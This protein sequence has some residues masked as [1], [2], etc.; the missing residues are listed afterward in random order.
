MSWSNKIENFWYL[1]SP[2]AWFVY[3]LWPFNLIFLAIVQAKR[4]LYYLG[5][6]KKQSFNKPVIVVGNISVGGTGK[7]PF[8]HQYVKLLEENDIRVGLVS[9]G[10][11]AKIKDFPHQVKESDQAVDVGDEA[12]LQFSSL[13]IP[14]VIDPNRSRAVKYLVDSNNVDLVISDDGLQHYKMDRQAEIVLFDGSRGLGNQLILPLGPLREPKQRLKSVNLV[15]ENKS[16]ID[17]GT[18]SESTSEHDAT[19]RLS[20]VCF[21]QLTTNEIFALESFKGQKIHGVAAIGN[22]EHFFNSLDK[23]CKIESRR[24]YADHYLFKE[25]DFEKY[26]SE[27]V[28]MTEKDASKCFPFAKENWYYLQVEMVFDNDLQIRLLDLAKT[29]I[30]NHPSV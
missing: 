28:I 29:L 2:R 19:V 24:T 21:K 7:T 1:S 6:L 17:S 9:R 26:N 14:F 15:I 16:E 12:Y 20:N 11:K 8:I 22:P 27:I 4:F 23:L 10:Y 30:K 5:L 25:V 13:N 18:E 3:L